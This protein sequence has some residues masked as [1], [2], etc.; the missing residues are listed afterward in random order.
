MEYRL[1]SISSYNDRYDAQLWPFDLSYYI[2][3]RYIIDRLSIYH[4]QIIDRSSIDHRQII[5]VVY[6]HIFIHIYIYIYIYTHTRD[7]AAANSGNPVPVI[8]P[9]QIVLCVCVYIYIYMLCVSDVLLCISIY[10]H[11]IYILYNRSQITKQ[12]N[13]EH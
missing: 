13:C 11:Y 2:K 9:C 10:S 4:R 5:D 7:T 8:P 1:V 6:K 3:H 12:S